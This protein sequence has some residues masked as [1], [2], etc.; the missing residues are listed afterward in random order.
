MDDYAVE[1]CRMLRTAGVQEK[2]SCIF[3]VECN[4]LSLTG[5]ITEKK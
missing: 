1:N 5:S 4:N 3:L 2:N